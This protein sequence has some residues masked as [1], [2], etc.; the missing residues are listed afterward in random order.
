[1]AYTERNFKTK[2]ALIEAVRRG[3]PVGYYNPGLGAPIGP[4]DTIY[5]EG[6]HYP[7]PHTWCAKAK[8]VNGCIVEVK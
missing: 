3:E 1:M 6:P 4:N 7:Q 8:L 5:L 2:K